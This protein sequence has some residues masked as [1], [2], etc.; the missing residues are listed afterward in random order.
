MKY[1]SD[2]VK[3]LNELGS[4]A[5]TIAKAESRMTI[6]TQ[7]EDL[8]QDGQRGLAYPNAKAVG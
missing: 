7:N 4:T 5:G 3:I 6:C 8:V 1:T 2:T